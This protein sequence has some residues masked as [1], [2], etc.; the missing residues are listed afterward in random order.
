MRAGSA[1]GP[2]ASSVGSAS[3][4]GPVLP[5]RVSV[6][7]CSSPDRS[8]RSVAVMVV[9][10]RSAS[11]TESWS[12]WPATSAPTL[13]APFAPPTTSVSV[14]ATSVAPVASTASV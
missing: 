13:G 3:V 5:A 9:P 2:S 11:V 4:K 6:T 14:M 10:V 1:S 8:L 7:G 12:G